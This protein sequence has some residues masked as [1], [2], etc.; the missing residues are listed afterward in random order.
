[1]TRQPWELSWDH[2]MCPD[3]RRALYIILPYGKMQEATMEHDG[4]S[5]ANTDG[6]MSTRLEARLSIRCD[7]NE[8]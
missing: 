6:D 8:R 1:M 2:D 3:A 7:L 5:F 4:F